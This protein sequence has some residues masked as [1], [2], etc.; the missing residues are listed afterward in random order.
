MAF[1]FVI[2]LVNRKCHQAENSLLGALIVIKKKKA[3]SCATLIK[4]GG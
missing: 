3:R 2:M 4:K 1:L